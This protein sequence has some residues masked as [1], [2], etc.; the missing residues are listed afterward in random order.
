[1][2]VVE[3]IAVDGLNDRTMSVCAISSSQ[4]WHSNYAVFIC[5]QRYDTHTTWKIIIYTDELNYWWGLWCALPYKICTLGPIHIYRWIRSKE[6]TNS[7]TPISLPCR[8]LKAIGRC[9]VYLVLSVRVCGVYAWSW[10]YH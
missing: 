2:C 6:R 8:M 10:V 3:L 4:K 7:T 9:S 1:M 5:N